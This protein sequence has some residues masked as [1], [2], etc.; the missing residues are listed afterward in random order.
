MAT[1]NDT[2]QGAG[3]ESDDDSTGAMVR[4]FTV[5]GGRT[6]VSVPNL[7]LTTQVRAID[8]SQRTGRHH[9]RDSAFLLPEYRKI[10]AECRQ[11]R[12]I[13]ELAATLHL[14][15]MSVSVLVADLINDGY[16]AALMEQDTPSLAFLRRVKDGIE[17]VL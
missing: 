12:A 7:G 9:R 6:Q 2:H 13:A 5:T 11:S 8:S 15:A 3:R 16:L 4:P 17:R 14:P 10:I 1:G